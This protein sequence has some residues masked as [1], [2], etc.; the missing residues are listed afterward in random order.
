ME[1]VSGF[2]L[3]ALLNLTFTL[4]LHAATTVVVKPLSELLIYPRHSAPAE[5]IN[6]DHAMLAAP[7]PGIVD[8]VWVQVGAKV[9]AGQTL[10]EL[11][12]RDHRLQ[13]LA[14]KG[15][16]Q[17]LNAQ[18]TL[19]RQQLQRADRLLKQQNAAQEMRD[20]RAA[21][22]KS[23]LAQQQ[24]SNARLKQADLS[25]ERC[26][27]TAPFAGTVTGREVSIG[28]WLSPGQPMLSILS[29]SGSEISSML[30][31]SQLDSLR[32][33][34]EISYQ[35]NDKRFPLQLRQ[36]VPYLDKRARTLEVRLTFTA[37]R[38]ISGSSGRIIWQA[39][40]GMLPVQ[41]IVSRAGRLGVIYLDNGKAQ[42]YP[43][44]AAIEGQPAVVDLPPESQIIV[45]GQHGVS[46]NQPVTAER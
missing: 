28:E 32:Q 37:E 1:R 15:E 34:K 8:K 10:L 22:L 4:P 30:N 42:F 45:E 29:D 20:Q 16:H 14:A 3:L 24:S 26:R 40:A 9:S 23:L 19:A 43:L 25:V 12:C 31:S 35:H 6:E 13:Q 21:E 5:V 41:Y 17:A 38:A 11:D 27:P 36:V 33:A 39:E 44:P 7:I 46:H 18:V 2:F